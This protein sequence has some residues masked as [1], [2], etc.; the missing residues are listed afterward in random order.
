MVRHRRRETEQ[1]TDRQARDARGHRRV[2]LHHAD[3]AT[4]GTNLCL[5]DGRTL[6]FSALPDRGGCPRVRSALRRISLVEIIVGGG[7]ASAAVLGLGH[8]RQ[9]VLPVSI[10]T[11]LALAVEGSPTVVDLIDEPPVETQVVPA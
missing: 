3:V 10:A 2:L 8:R 9:H 4:D 7:R 1:D 11:A 6:R 5:T